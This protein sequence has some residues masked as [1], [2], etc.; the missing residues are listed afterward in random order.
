[1][2]SARPGTVDRTRP[3][4]GFPPPPPSS[5]RWPDRL[6][7]ATTS[8]V[9]RIGC[10]SFWAAVRR[11]DRPL[12]LASQQ[13]VAR[14]LD[15]ERRAPPRPH[16]HAPP[17]PAPLCGVSLECSAVGD[18]GRLALCGHLSAVAAN[19][20]R[21]RDSRLSF[22]IESYSHACMSRRRMLPLPTPQ[23]T[24]RPS[25]SRPHTRPSSTYWRPPVL[26]L[27]LPTS[28]LPRPTS[29][30]PSPARR[31]GKARRTTSTT[32][33]VAQVDAQVHA[34]FR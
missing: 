4:L 32:R 17:W 25:T 16:R 5:H 29:S 13:C 31:S 9:G 2:G 15:R 22:L 20:S 18:A 34:V 28:S 11:R 30:L 23:R 14:P 6:S 33:V 8:G 21:F 10:C 12:A 7:R 27:P 26:T 3:D 19:E 24:C 1:M